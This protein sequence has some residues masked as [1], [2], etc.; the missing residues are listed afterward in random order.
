M[1]EGSRV[2]RE[3][4]ITLGRFQGGAGKGGQ[5]LRARAEIADHVLVYRNTRMAVIEAR[6]WDKPPTEGL[7]QAK[8]SAAKR[9]ARSAFA[10]NGQ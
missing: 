9:A 4:G 5:S 10:T 6:A 3:H 7:G 2:L 1:V 8:N